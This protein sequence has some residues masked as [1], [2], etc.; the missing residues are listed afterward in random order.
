MQFL[1]GEDRCIVWHY[2][3]KNVDHMQLWRI[4]SMKKIVLLT[5]N[6]IPQLYQR[7]C[8]SICNGQYY[9]DNTI[10]TTKCY[11]YLFCN[12]VGLKVN[13]KDFENCLDV[14]LS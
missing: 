13:L 3:N 5:Q 2:Q 1:S 12:M 6:K 8:Y 9:G 14:F 10:S 7:D 4:C 11:N